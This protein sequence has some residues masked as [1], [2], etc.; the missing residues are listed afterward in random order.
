MLA[1][2]CPARVSPASQRRENP[3]TRGSCSSK[4]RLWPSIGPGLSLQ[5]AAQHTA[6]AEGSPGYGCAG[7]SL[8][9]SAGVS[10]SRILAWEQEGKESMQVAAV[11]APMALPER[12]GG[13]KQREEKKKKKKGKES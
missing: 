12:Q 13:Q 11:Q 3:F 10:L 8:N 5:R 9:G 4:I 2:L 6:R 7:I 1:G